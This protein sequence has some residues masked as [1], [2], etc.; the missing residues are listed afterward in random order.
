M[1]PRTDKTK[2]TDPDIEVSLSPIYKQQLRREYD[3]GEI[4]F[5]K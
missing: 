1:F 3:S 2:N 4:C 5:A